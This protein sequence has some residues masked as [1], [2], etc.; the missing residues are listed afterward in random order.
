MKFCLILLPLILLSV[1]VFPQSFTEPQNL[2]TFNITVNYDDYT[3][4]TQF[5]KDYTKCKTPKNEL[6]YHWYSSQKI[7]E[8]KGGYDGKLLHGYYKSFYLNDQLFESGN[9]KYGVKHGEWKN[10]YADGKIKEIT[11]WKNGKKHGNYVLYNEYG[12][13]MASCKFKNDELTGSFKTYDVTGKLSSVRTYKKGKEIIATPKLKKQSSTLNNGPNLKD[14]KSK[15]RLF[16]KWFKK[17]HQS[18][19]SKNTTSA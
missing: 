18:R 19:V 6:T 17:R 3:I 5:L 12:L 1:N 9:F 2:K 13:L 4:K 11:N 14:K 7:I 16:N 8:T 10:W 15:N